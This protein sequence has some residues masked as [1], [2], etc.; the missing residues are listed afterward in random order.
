MA[1]IRSFAVLPAAGESRRMGQP[2]LLL[3]FRGRTIIERVIGN[4][5]ASQVEKIVV[6]LGPASAEA[7]PLAAHPRTQVVMAAET[8][9]DMKASVSLGLS[10]IEANCG[11][12]ADDA[13]LLAPADMPALAPETIDRVIAEYVRSPGSIVVPRYNGKRGHPVA[14]PW[15]TA[16]EVAG[17]AADRGI[18]V[19][20]GQH[21]VIEIEVDDAG[22]VTDL[23]TPDDYQRLAGGE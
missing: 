11:P 23:D 1:A 13:W 18:D 22:A 3:P 16:A 21:P 14:F 20:L 5:A 2:K 17:I 15:S 10:W 19:L 8:P 9:P 7:A 6:V 4:W 12:T